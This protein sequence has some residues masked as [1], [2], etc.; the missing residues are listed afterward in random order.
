MRKAILILLTA[1][2]ILFSPCLQAQHVRNSSSRISS[3]PISDAGAK[4]S[5]W[6]LSGKAPEQMADHTVFSQ[7]MSN[8]IEVCPTGGQAVAVI[9]DLPLVTQYT[10]F[11][12]Y[13]WDESGLPC[14]A[15]CLPNQIPFSLDIPQTGQPVF[16]MR[17]YMDG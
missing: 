15:P 7:A 2:G 14:I 17:R 4:K 10:S 11:K 8:M 16:V 6:T 12:Y 9:T 5:F 1:F 3:S 13:F